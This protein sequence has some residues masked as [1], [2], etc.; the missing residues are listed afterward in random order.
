MYLCLHVCALLSRH[1]LLI[2]LKKSRWNFALTN[3]DWPNW[4][5]FSYHTDPPF[6]YLYFNIYMCVCLYTL[7]KHLQTRL[8]AVVSNFTMVVSSHSNGQSATGVATL[9][10][11]AGYTHI[12]RYVLQINPL[13]ANSTCCMLFVVCC[14]CHKMLCHCLL[15]ALVCRVVNC[16]VTIDAVKW[17]H[18]D[19]KRQTSS[20]QR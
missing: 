17:F 10:H 3:A 11:F 8:F 1:K 4:T 12:H 15:H 6:I 9:C 20:V 7:L 19:L 18:L 5:T 16:A 14:N 2:L 13:H